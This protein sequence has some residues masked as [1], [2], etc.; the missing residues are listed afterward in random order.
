[1]GWPD[2]TYEN[3][4]MHSFIRKSWRKEPILETYYY[5]VGGKNVTVD[6][7]EADR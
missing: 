4:K 2:N 3:L 7:K 5:M 6:L 1:M